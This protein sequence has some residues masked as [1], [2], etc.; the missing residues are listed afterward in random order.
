MSKVLTDQ[1][2]KRTGGTAMDVPAAGK[3]P[4][5]NIADDAIGASQIADTT[6]TTAK[7]AIDPT[8]ASNLSSGSVPLG[9]LGNVPATDLSPIEDDIAVLGFQVAAANDLAI[10]NLRDQIVDTFQTAAGVDASAST[11]ENY[12]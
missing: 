6:I 4:Q 3:W 5:G 2:E 1:I 8:N 7:M 9:Q 10:Y 12:D 11:N